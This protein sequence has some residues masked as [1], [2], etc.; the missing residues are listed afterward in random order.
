MLNGLPK[1]FGKIPIGAAAMIANLVDVIRN[2][3]S[4][5]LSGFS[6]VIEKMI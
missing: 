6:N 5:L 1:L 4:F 3:G 2:A